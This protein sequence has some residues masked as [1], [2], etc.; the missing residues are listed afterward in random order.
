M[1]PNPRDT[2]LFAPDPFVRRGV[3]IALEFRGHDVFP[4]V[5]LE[6]AI[7]VAR[8]GVHLRIVVIASELPAL[9]TFETIK[10]EF[11]A[12]RDFS[13]PQ[14]LV[15]SFSGSDP[16]IERTV[17]TSGAHF[18]YGA[19]EP[20]RMLIRKLDLINLLLEE[21]PFVTIEHT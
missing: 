16:I 9:E 4:C 12:R 7:V 2:L 5:S 18:L 8:S 13:L 14:F 1:S 11:L 19:D 15:I 17:T 10:R 6:R 21:A 20:D 3:G